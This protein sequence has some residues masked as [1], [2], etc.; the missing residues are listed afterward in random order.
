MVAMEMSF[1]R[2]HVKQKCVA[3]GAESPVSAPP[4][5][6]ASLEITLAAE[7]ADPEVMPLPRVAHIQ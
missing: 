2:S 5:Q 6:S 3:P 4:Q 7:S 1:P